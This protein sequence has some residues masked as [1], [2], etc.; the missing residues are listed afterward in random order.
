MGSCWDARKRG[1]TPEQLAALDVVDTRQPHPVVAPIKGKRGTVTLACHDGKRV[2]EAT[3]YGALAIHRTGASARNPRYSI[4]HIATGYSVA[5]DLRPQAA[6][7]LVAALQP[8][9]WKFTSPKRVPPATR[10]QA[11]DIIRP[12][13]R[14]R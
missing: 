10:E 7:Q 4:T 12:F 6:R 13:L 3:L 2:V 11:R 9:D 5:A 14:R 8:L 1:L